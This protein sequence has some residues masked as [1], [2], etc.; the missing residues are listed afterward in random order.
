MSTH[1]TPGITSSLIPLPVIGGR[2][3]GVS[4]RGSVVSFHPREG[5]TVSGGALPRWRDLYVGTCLLA[6]GRYL[7]ITQPYTNTLH[8][9]VYHWWAYDT[10]SGEVTECRDQSFGGNEGMFT[11][12]LAVLAHPNHLYY[13]DPA[14]VYPHPDMRWGIIPPSSVVVVDEG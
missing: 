6:L 5:W 13:I 1:P 14:L 12:A 2:V 11:P 4:S 8:N 7:L 9:K 3:Y 10:I